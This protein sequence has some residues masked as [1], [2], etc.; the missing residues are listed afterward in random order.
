MSLHVTVIGAGVVGLTTAILL[1]HHGH[2][3]TL[4]SREFPGTLSIKYTSPWAGAHYR[5]LAGNNDSR[6]QKWELISYRTFVEL[7]KT[8]P[9]AGVWLMPGVDLYDTPP[10]KPFWYEREIPGYQVLAREEL[11]EGVAFGH[12]YDSLSINTSKYLAFLLKLFT[13]K[14]GATRRLE[15]GHLSEAVEEH[16]DVVVNCTGLGAKTLGGVSDSNVFPIRGQTVI[17]KSPHP[18]AKTITRIGEHFTY[19]IPRDNGEVVLGGT[20]QAHDETATPVQST[21]DAIL[22]R[23][24]EI[25]PELRPLEKIQIVREA[26][27][28]RPGRTGGTRLD[29]EWMNARG[30]KDV[31]LV[32]NYGHGGGGYQTSWGT[33]AEAVEIIAR[34][35]SIRKG[36][37]GGVLS[38]L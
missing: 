7:S 21:T 28:L 20:H 33:A 4:V 1:L 9:D 12:T 25:C 26:V 27:G 16:T 23:V 8:A 22:R 5:S 35:M 2:R 34:E 18:V 29:A 15:I 37:L 17:V 30:S 31:L 36:L 11:P 14:G 6:M 19:V 32:H 3:V 38:K 24:V 13:T 10:R